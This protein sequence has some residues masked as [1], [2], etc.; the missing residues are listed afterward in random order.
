MNAKVKYELVAELREHEGKGAS[1]RLRRL[2]D[3]IPAILYGGQE[4]ALPISLDQKKV[5]HALENP[6]FYSKILTLNL[7]DKK[8]Q[9]VLKDLQRHHYKKSI[10]HMDFLRVNP[11]DVIAMRVPIHFIGADVAPGVKDQAGIVNHY[12]MDLEVRCKVK[13]LPESIEVDI[14]KMELDQTIHISHLKLPEGVEAVALS[15]DNDLGVVSIHLPRVYVEEQP[16]VEAAAEAPATEV[17]GKETKEAAD[18]SKEK[19][20]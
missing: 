2:E 4:P 18:K 9:V 11:N 13:D 17:A 1:R 8:Q 14:S 7:A 6:V 15:H 5:M 12:M 16:V 10:L 3:K 19:G 20:A